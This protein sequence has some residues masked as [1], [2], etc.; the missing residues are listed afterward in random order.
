MRRSSPLA[1]PCRAALLL[2]LPCRPHA[3]RR[4][5]GSA[6][7][8]AQQGCLAFAPRW[9]TAFSTT[10]QQHPAS[11]LAVKRRLGSCGTSSV[12]RERRV[13]GALAAKCC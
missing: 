6:G 11:A 8:M 7:V 1:V 12:V 4:D 3:T 13:G 10:T 2:L 5:V 9:G